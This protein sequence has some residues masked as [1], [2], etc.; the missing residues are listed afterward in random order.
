MIHHC[1]QLSQPLPD[2]LGQLFTEYAKLGHITVVNPWV[3]NIRQSNQTPCKPALN[4]E[5]W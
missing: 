3:E 2:I 1:Y 4:N 5:N